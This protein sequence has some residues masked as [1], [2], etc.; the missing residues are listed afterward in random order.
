M[1]ADQ[2]ILVGTEPEHEAP[3]GHDT[4]APDASLLHPAP[5]GSPV[6]AHPPTF[7]YTLAK[8]AKTTILN[9]HKTVKDGVKKLLSP[10]QKNP[11]QEVDRRSKQLSGGASDSSN[12]KRAESD[13]WKRDL[14]HLLGLDANYFL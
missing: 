11:F 4:E 10:K 1:K 8:A 12:A 14:G 2:Q 9:A 13:N 6:R 5:D 3:N 7:G